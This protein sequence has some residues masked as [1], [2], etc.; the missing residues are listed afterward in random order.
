M[1]PELT[2]FIKVN[3]AILVFYGFYRLFCTKDTFLRWRRFTLLGFWCIAWIY[4]FINLQDWMQQHPPIQEL[5]TFYIETAYITSSPAI[6]SEIPESIQ[7][8]KWGIWF[9]FTGVTILG[10]RFFFQLIGILRLAHQCRRTKIAHTK[11][12]LLNKPEGPFSFFRWIFIHPDSMRNEHET[13]EILIHER[14]HVREWHS[15]DLLFS[16]L[17]CILCWMNPFSWLLKREVRDNLEYLADR[18]VIIS[19][20]DSKSYQYHLLG[21]T[22]QKAAATLYNHFN[23]LPIKKRIIMMNKKRTQNIGRTKYFMFFLFAITLMLFN[24]IESVARNTKEVYNQLTESLSDGNKTENAEKYTIALSKKES[25]LKAVQIKKIEEQ[26]KTDAPSVSTFYTH[27]P[28]TSSEKTDLAELYNFLK[29][30]PLLSQEEDGEVSI[31]YTIKDGK[32]TAFSVSKSL[33]SEPNKFQCTKIST[34]TYVSTTK[35]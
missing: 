25:A 20:H 34:K 8:D 28:G 27:V 31:K 2:Y 24:N 26:K 19:G 14:T 23:V 35:E 33:D 29:E 12:C 21:L 15:V 17:N 13:E 5:T 10:I 16:E 3:I 4:P 11:V 6:P 18:Q 30:K 32:I 9:Y 1:L 7:W 22:Y